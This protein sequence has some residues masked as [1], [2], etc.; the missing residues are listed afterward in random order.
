MGYS[1][2]VA[3]EAHTMWKT[4]TVIISDQLSQLGSSFFDSHGISYLYSE[5]RSAKDW[6][7]GC[8]WLLLTF[9]NW[10][11]VERH[12]CSSP[13]F[14]QLSRLNH[15]LSPRHLSCASWKIPLL[16][17]YLYS[18]SFQTL[19]LCTVSTRSCHQQTLYVVN[20]FSEDS[21]HILV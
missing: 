21:S 19:L 10:R 12:H 18:L 11:S 5:L 4:V 9:H 1:Q 2:A 16:I 20:L 13:C 15:P 7:W 17:Q 14:P 3:Q 8:I 6:T